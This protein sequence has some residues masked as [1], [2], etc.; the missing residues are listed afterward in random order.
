M[1]ITEVTYESF[2]LIRIIYI[3]TFNVLVIWY[4]HA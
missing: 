4:C 2:L 3:T 1:N